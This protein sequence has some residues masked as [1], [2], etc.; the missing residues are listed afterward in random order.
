MR[1][2]A[3][4]AR[5]TRR[6]ALSSRCLRSCGSSI[7]EVMAATEFERRRL[8]TMFVRGRSGAVRARRD[9]RLRSLDHAVDAL[10]AV[11]LADPGEAGAELFQAHERLVQPKL[12]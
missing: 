9:A 5:Q 7:V 11:E 2:T 1:A 6:C 4:C 10:D 8:A 12:Y 3:R